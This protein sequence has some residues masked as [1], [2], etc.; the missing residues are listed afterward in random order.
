MAVSSYTTN[1]NLPLFEDGTGGWGSGD[2]GILEWLDEI[3]AQIENIISYENQVVCYE[4]K[5][6]YYL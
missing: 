2:N 6:V 4:N 3:M 1:Y 5:V